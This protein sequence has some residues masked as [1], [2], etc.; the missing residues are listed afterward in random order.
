MSQYNNVFTLTEKT[1][2]EEVYLHCYSNMYV[3]L[4]IIY[5]RTSI[6]KGKDTNKELKYLLLLQLFNNMWSYVENRRKKYICMTKLSNK[7]TSKF[8]CM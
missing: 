3:L 8:A 5:F 7:R 6:K 1:T 4:F 2:T